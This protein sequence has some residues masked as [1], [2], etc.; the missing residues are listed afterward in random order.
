MSF[1]PERSGVEESRNVIGEAPTSAPAEVPPLRCASVGVPYGVA[2]A[3]YVSPNH[4]AVYQLLT[5]RFR[6]GKLVS[7]KH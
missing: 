7:I 1:R 6:Y 2:H 5:L 3:L 4:L